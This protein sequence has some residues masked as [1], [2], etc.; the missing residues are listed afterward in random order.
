MTTTT[1]PGPMTA[2]RHGTPVGTLTLA[3]TEQGLTICSFAPPDAR[4]AVLPGTDTPAATT[5]SDKGAGNKD[6]GHTHV[7]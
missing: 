2:I 5:G 7:P 4:L 1:D 3:A 6:S